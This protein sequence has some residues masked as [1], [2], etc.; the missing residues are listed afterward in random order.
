[1]MIHKVENW[2]MQKYLTEVKCKHTWSKLKSKHSNKMRQKK[3]IKWDEKEAD[4]VSSPSHKKEEN[5]A[6]FGWTQFMLPYG[7]K[8]LH[9]AMKQNT[10]KKNNF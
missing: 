9:F 1:M 6:T 4:K 8:V 7:S 2:N 10:K 5:S 3:K